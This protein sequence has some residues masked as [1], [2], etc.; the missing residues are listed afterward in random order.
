[1]A[2]CGRNRISNQIENIEA[3]AGLLRQVHA[4][5]ACCSPIDLPGIAEKYR[6]FL[7]ARHG[8][9]AFAPN[10]VRI[11]RESSRPESVTC[12]HNDIVAT[13]VIDTGKL[14]L[15]DWEYAR[16]NDPLFDLASAIGF[17]NLDKRRQQVFLN[18]YAGGADSEL[19][20][21]LARQ[22]RIFDA[23]QWLWLA[24]RQLASPRSEQARRL[25]DL[26]QRIR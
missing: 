22:V 21:R 4:L 12:C 6:Q 9:Y 17:H 10:C 16:D 23:I 13:N 25:N 11:I 5:P 2:G 1:M 3:L 7:E 15:I 8:L 24:T 18:A 26:Q 19:R 20:E 14:N